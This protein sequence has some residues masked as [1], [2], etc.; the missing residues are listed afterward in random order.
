LIGKVLFWKSESKKYQTITAENMPLVK[1]HFTWDILTARTIVVS[2][3][4]DA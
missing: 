2:A 4:K 1:A 3:R